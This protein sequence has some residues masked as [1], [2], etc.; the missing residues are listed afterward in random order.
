LYNNN[1]DVLLS[2]LCR[3]VSS[4]SADKRGGSGLSVSENSLQFAFSSSLVF[5]YVIHST[6][7]FG[8]FTHNFFL[9][10]PLKSIYRSTTEGIN[11]NNMITKQFTRYRYLKIMLIE[12]GLTS[13]PR[14]VK[15]MTRF[16]KKAMLLQ[17]DHVM[18][19]FCLHP[20]TLQLLFM[21][22]TL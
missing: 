15:I 20:I 9:F 7:T 19:H 2:T 17:G 14:H 3:C 21:L 5:C 4:M 13:A 8:Y 10:S 22:V 18:P 1:I 6:P 16:Y 11:K 12:H